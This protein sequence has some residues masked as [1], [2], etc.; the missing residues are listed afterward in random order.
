MLGRLSTP[1]D[2]SGTAGPGA[3]MQGLVPS[4]FRLTVT[5]AAVVAIALGGPAA[6]GAAGFGA[7]VP[8]G[9]VQLP[10]G[11]RDAGPV[12]P[13]AQ[14]RATVALRPRR[15]AALAAYAQAVSDPSSPV[16]HRYLTVAQFRRR[17]A[18][19]PARVGAVRAQLRA[20][21]LTVATTSPNG[22][23]IPVS[24]SARTVSDAFGIS[25]HRY[26]LPG[27]RTAEA[28]TSRPHGGR[29]VQAV[30]G[31]DTVAPSAGAVV[32]ARQARASVADAT[33]L[34]RPHGAGPQACASA[35][36]AAAQSVSLTPD[37]VAARYGIANFQAAGDEGQGV[38]VALYELEPFSATDV[39]AYQSCMGTGASVSV[40]T[41]DG[42]AGVGPGS[43]EAA[44]DVEDLIGLAP[45][46]SIRVY[47]GPQTGLGAYDTYSQIIADD[48]AQVVSTSW[49][50]CE[51]QLGLPAALAESVLFQEAAVQGQSILAASGDAG[52][53]DCGDGV[54]SVDDPAA[55]PWVTGVGGTTAGGTS[56]S[57]WNDGFGAGG[58]GAS[59]FWGQPAWQGAVAQPDA[60]VGCGTGTCREV[61]DL[62]T[63]G[64]P[65]TGYVAFYRGGW[66][67]VGGTSVSAPT[68]AAVV[69]LTDASPACGGRPLGFLN[70]GLYALANSGAFA[71]VTSGTNAWAGVS[72]FVAGPGYDMTSGL[73]TPTAAL[74]PALCHDSLSLSAPPRQSWT[75]GHPVSLALSAT[76]AQGASISWTATG[77]PAGLTLNPATGRITG[78]PTAAGR[79][80]VTATA[81]DAGGATATAGFTVTILRD[82]ALAP[83]KGAAHT[84]AAASPTVVVRRL[85]GRNGRVGQGVRFRVHAGGGHRPALSF[86]AA[87]LPPGLRIGSRTGV[88]SG[89]LRVAGRT[90]VTV[91]AADGSGDVAR[92]NFRW[93]VSARRAPHARR[94]TQGVHRDHRHPQAAQRHRR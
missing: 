36:T 20:R 68:V 90:T 76:S 63:D 3:P 27:G 23:S 45:K 19:A 73:G 14:L 51:A 75:T 47:E 55:Q 69:A 49:G 48:A 79:G 52:S 83:A 50:L 37:Q 60:A 39:A 30:V 31:L 7:R 59:Q 72:G 78:T 28:T 17:F 42:G 33:T 53:D 15:P 56:D 5:S 21:G 41:V 2:R 22:L 94:R 34:D 87:G 35:S 46:A 8:R 44:M 71:D 26:L 54:E 13:A 57:A 81:T 88:I 93:T 6:A 4:R 66:H 11:A 1:A 70:P 10:G 58:G 67:S 77:L 64:D 61:P 85:R 38:T 29:L 65:A 43:G 32:R 16:Y 82:P 91:N 18:P 84:G 40:Q 25:I 9:G 89:T 80:T 24:A 12:A 74:G 62:S 92:S 86:T